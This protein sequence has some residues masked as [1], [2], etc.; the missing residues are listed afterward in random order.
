M[1]SNDDGFDN[2]ILVVCHMSLMNYLFIATGLCN[3]AG[4][5]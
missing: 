5:S 3:H 2:G 4:W 1:R